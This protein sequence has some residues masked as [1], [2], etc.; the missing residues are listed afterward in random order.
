MGCCC[1]KRVAAAAGTSDEE[2]LPHDD[3]ESED[4][5]S[6]GLSAVVVGNDA[7]RGRDE[8]HSVL[9]GVGQQLARRSRLKPLSGLAA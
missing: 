3:E 5:W 6:E 8:T 2:L 4:E 9:L 1:G 7:V